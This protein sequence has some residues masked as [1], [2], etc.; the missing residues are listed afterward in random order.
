M[1][2]FNLPNIAKEYRD[3]YGMGM[4]TL[5]LA[6]IMYNENNALFRS[7]DHARSVLRYIEGKK[8]KRDA[9]DKIKESK[10][11]M[12]EERPRNP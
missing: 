3:K 9:S 4:P 12:K 7:I 10:Y 8:G 2:R 1:S 5:T 11:F 6:R